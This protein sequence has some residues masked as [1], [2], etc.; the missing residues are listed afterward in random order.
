[1]T[2]QCCANLCPMHVDNSLSLSLFSL[3]IT[4]LT[5]EVKALKE[6]LGAQTKEHKHLKSMFTRVSE[7]KDYL[8]RTQEMYEQ[9]KRELQQ[10][11]TAKLKEN[12]K[13]SAEKE[14]LKRKMKGYVSQEKEKYDRLSKQMQRKQREIRVKDEKLRQ[15]KELIKNSPLPPDASSRTPLRESGMPNIDVRIL[16]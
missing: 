12:E 8:L 14:Q 16:R 2:A 7:Q 13:E 10:E 15:V 11:L 6:K 9:D 3:K 5:A 4:Q 1:M